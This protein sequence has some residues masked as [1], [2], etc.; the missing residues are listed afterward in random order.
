MNVR[1]PAWPAVGVALAIFVAPVGATAANRE[2]S[3]PA[4]VAARAGLVRRADL[5]RG[6]SQTSAAP[7]TAAALTC[8]ADRA[9]R[10]AVASPTWGSVTATAFVS[11]TSYGFSGRAQQRRAWRATATAAMGRCLERQFAESSSH[12]VALVATGVRRVSAPAW[13]G[14]PTGATLR[15]YLV[16]GTATGAGQQLSVALEV[17]LVGDG[18]WIGEDELSS[19]GG[20]AP[21]SVLGRAAAD[22]ARR[23]AA[24][25]A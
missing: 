11:G 15:A 10:A 19:E 25:P 5:G 8:T 7:G 18:A 12:G 24:A 20:S 17:V 16:T 14:A 9:I 1:R 13:R 3:P 6:W 23:A 4:T 21:A 22:Q 2:S